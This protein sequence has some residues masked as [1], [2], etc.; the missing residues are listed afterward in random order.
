MRGTLNYLQTALPQTKL[1]LL[2]RDILDCPEKTIAEWQKNDF[3]IAID[4]FYHQIQIVGTPEV[5]DTVREYRFPPTIAEKVRYCGYLHRQPGQKSRTRIRQE[6]QVSQR[7]RLIL[8]TP[9]GGE[10]GY[11]LVDNYLSAL[12]LLPAKYRI[13]SLIICGPEMPKKQK[14][15]VERA[16]ENNSQVRVGEFTDDLMSYINAADI[17]VSMAGYNTVCEILS[18]GKPS[19]IIPRHKPSQEQS[20]RAERMASLGLIKTLIPGKEDFSPTT[21]MNLLLSQLEDQ[22]KL[23]LNLDMNGLFRVQNYLLQLMAQK[24]CEHQLNRIYQKYTSLP[25]LAIDRSAV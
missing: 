25:A 15:L 14:Q 24:V 7:E 20:I 19:V 5:F 13:K 17:V 9:G 6:L 21:L 3:Y 4:K 22:Q 16:A 1:V 8:V 23:K 10:D 2:L 12:A 11:E 18:A